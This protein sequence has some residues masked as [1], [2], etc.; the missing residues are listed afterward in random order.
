MG[1]NRIDSA[2]WSS[3]ITTTMFGLGGLH[4][5]SPKVTANTRTDSPT[6]MCRRPT[7]LPLPS[8]PS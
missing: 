6:G 1:M 8:A 7:T 5:A 2:V 3:V 4:D